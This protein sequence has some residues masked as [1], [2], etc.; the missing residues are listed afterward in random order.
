M[1]TKACKHS[2]GSIKNIKSCSRLARAQRACK[3]CQKVPRLIFISRAGTE[4]FAIEK[5][6]SKENRDWMEKKQT[7]HGKLFANVTSRFIS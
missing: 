1:L 6:S 4:T 7:L 5:L 3:R 2:N